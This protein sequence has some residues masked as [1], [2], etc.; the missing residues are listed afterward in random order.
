MQEVLYVD[1]EAEIPK[2]ETATNPN[3]RAKELITSATSL[4]ELEQRIST[5]PLSMREYWKEEIA[6][7]Q[8]SFT[9]NN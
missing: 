5:L 6:A 2:P 3:E 7:K 9:E 1:N 4:K 8:E